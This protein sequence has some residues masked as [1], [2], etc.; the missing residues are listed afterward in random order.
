MTKLS[1]HEIIKFRSI[2]QVLIDE[3]TILSVL[4]KKKE[5][6]E[7]EEEEEVNPGFILCLYVF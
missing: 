4:A 3:V 6:E 5:E 2:M 7:E 1:N